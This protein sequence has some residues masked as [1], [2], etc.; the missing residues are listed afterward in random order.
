[1]S[2][3]DEFKTGEHAKIDITLNPEDDDHNPIPIGNFDQIVIIYYYTLNGVVKFSWHALDPAE[4]ALAAEAATKGISVRQI[5]MNGNV[6]ETIIPPAD[7]ADASLT[8]EQKVP[9]FAAVR[10]E[11]TTDVVTKKNDNVAVGSMIKSITEGY[12]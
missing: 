3:N 4:P 1:M 7:T 5:T 12:L 11:D 8:D 2:L 6:A 9:V 10:L